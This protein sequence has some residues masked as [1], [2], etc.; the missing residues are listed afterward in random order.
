MALALLPAT[1][2]TA[3]S[4]AAIEVAMAA[5]AVPSSP[6]PRHEE[7]DGDV[8]TMRVWL[9]RWSSTSPHRKFLP[10]SPFPLPFS[11]LSLSQ[12]ATRQCGMYAGDII[13]FPPSIGALLSAFPPSALSFSPQIQLSYHFNLFPFF[14]SCCFCCH[15]WCSLLCCSL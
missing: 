8:V 13:S 12:H 14:F 3:P 5:V 15:S 6:V 2:P 7:P 1:K 10:R 4:S 9:E 11:H